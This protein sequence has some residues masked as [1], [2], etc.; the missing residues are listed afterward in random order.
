[1]HLHFA[2]GH[3]DRLDDMPDLALETGG[4]FAHRGVPFLLGPR[5]GFGM[6]HDGA[7]F[8]GAGSLGLGGFLRRRLEQLCEFVGK[9]DQYRCLD[10]ENDGVK[11]DAPKVARRRE[12]PPPAA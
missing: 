3:R 12:K 1:M 11:H 7:R 8:G 4:E 10:D 2:G 6:L 9:P 5:F